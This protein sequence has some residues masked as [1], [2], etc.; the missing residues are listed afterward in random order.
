VN[1]I[2]DGIAAYTR[3]VRSSQEKLTG[4][5]FDLECIDNDLDALRHQLD[6]NPATVLS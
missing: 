2:N 5:Q 6:P 3:F 1:R 4:L